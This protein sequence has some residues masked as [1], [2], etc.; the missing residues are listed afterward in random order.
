MVMVGTQQRVILVVTLLS[1]LPMK[2]A[3][4]SRQPILCEITISLTR[5]PSTPI[6]L[7]SVSSHLSP[8]PRQ[9]HPLLLLL[10][11]AP[12]VYLNP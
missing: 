11:R 2:I 8:L 1:L 9:T 10:H 7:E 5:T 6:R 12:P 4:N 3:R